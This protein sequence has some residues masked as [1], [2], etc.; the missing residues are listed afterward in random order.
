MERSFSFLSK[1]GYENLCLWLPTGVLAAAKFCFLKSKLL[2]R[3]KTWSSLDLYF[4]EGC[5]VDI[6]AKLGRYYVTSA[7]TLAVSIIAKK[8]V[9]L[10]QPGR[11]EETGSAP[12]TIM[13]HLSE[14]VYGI[15][16]SVLFDNTCPAPI[17]QK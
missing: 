5:G 9:L 12:K 15:F 17:L 10:D 3:S 6:L 8:E 11:E 4:P 16:N 2:S 7:F 14:G 13:Y 1:A